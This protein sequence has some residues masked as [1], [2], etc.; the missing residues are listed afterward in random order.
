MNKVPL[1]E[2]ELLEMAGKPVYCPELECYGIIS[3]DPI[4]RWAN[5]PF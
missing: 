1:T 4:G 5:I 2:K 3:C